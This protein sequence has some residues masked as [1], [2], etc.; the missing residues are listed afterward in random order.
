[1]YRAFVSSVG[2]AQLA[3]DFLGQ[4]RFWGMI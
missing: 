3:D 2:L 1:V 4:S